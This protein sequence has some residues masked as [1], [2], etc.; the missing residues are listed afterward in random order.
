MQ[1]RSSGVASGRLTELIEVSDM[2]TSIGANIVNR[3]VF[4]VIGGLFALTSVAQADSGVVAVYETSPDKLWA[5]VDFH[6]PS[7][8]I[9]PPIVASE[10]SGEGVGATKINTLGGDG[11]K[12]HLLLAHYN[13]DA[14]A[15]NYTIQDSPLPVKN[16]VGVVRVTDHGN[17][18][19]QLSWQGS[20]V[21]NGV[22]EEKADEILGGFYA[23]IADKIG[24]SFKRVK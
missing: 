5:L 9:M 3:T 13:P 7:E 4:A 18:Q 17:G 20:Y 2:G 15:F 22:S 11:G 6:Q 24:Q 23:A 14:M 8:N 21:A 19:A 10:R 12:V 16:Y 1:R